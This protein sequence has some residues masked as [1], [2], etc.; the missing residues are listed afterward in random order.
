MVFLQCCFKPAK[1]AK[2]KVEFSNEVQKEFYTNMYDVFNT[3]C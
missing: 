3:I 1:E 2:W